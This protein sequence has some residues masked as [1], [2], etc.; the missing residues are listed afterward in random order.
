MTKLKEKALVNVI[1]SVDFY[2]D[3]RS[4]ICHFMT[5]EKAIVNLICYVKFYIDVS[6]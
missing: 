2:I 6:C 4:Y 3:F 5:K 1:C